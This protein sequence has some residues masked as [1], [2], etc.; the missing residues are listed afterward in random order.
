M[1]EDWWNYSSARLKAPPCDA[2]TAGRRRMLQVA[3]QSRICILHDSRCASDILTGAAVLYWRIRLQLPTMRVQLS[4]STCLTYS[5]ALLV[6]RVLRAYLS[7]EE[8]SMA[9]PAGD[10]PWRPQQWPGG[11]C[12]PGLQ[13]HRARLCGAQ[14]PVRRALPRV[15]RHC[16]RPGRHLQGR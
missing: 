7:F 16:G 8:L 5:V 3:S 6:R 9:C 14:H 10:G 1:L 13:Q 15:Q 12:G 2:A 4:M 11:V